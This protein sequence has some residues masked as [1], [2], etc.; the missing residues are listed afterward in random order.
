MRGRWRQLKHQWRWERKWN[1]RDDGRQLHI[2][3][4]W[5]RERSRQNEGDYHFHFDGQLISLFVRRIGPPCGEG[6]FVFE[7]ICGVIGIERYFDE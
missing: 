7:G 2:H 3:R 4:H 5:N 6:Q 1:P